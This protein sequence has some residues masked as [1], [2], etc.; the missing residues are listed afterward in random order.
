MWNSLPASVI[1]EGNIVLLSSD[2]RCHCGL[3]SGKIAGF[4]MDMN[5]EGTL[6]PNDGKICSN[7]AAPHW[8]S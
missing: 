3:F 2:N 1:S 7:F 8:E 4:G 5:V 6:T